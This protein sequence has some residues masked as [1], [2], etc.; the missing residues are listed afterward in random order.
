[1][2]VRSWWY[3]HGGTLMVVR[4]WWYAHG[5]TLVVVRSWWYAHGGFVPRLSCEVV[6]DRH[7]LYG[8]SWHTLRRLL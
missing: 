6:S 3:A 1:M 8:R 5:G 7:L 4:S 2:V